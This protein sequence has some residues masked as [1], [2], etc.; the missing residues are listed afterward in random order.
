[1]GSFVEA[2]SNI[3]F[4]TVTRTGMFSN[5]PLETVV[6]VLQNAPDLSYPL[7]QPSPAA[8]A[9]A[10]TESLTSMEEEEEESPP[11]SLVIPATPEQ[12]D[13]P[14]STTRTATA[15]LTDAE[16]AQFES[17]EVTAAHIAQLKRIIVRL[18]HA[19]SPP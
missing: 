13:S 16:Q 19:S 9:A 5:I 10:A 2:A 18:L 4:P 11:S 1:V 3:A 6:R 15:V 7:S 17:D 8:T 12:R 14:T